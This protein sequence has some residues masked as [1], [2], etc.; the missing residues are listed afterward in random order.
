MFIYYYGNPET[1]QVSYLKAW[2]AKQQAM[3]KRFGTFEASYCNL[4]RM[5]EVIKQSNPGTYTAFKESEP[6]AN[7]I[8]TFH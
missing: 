1:I 5:L 8:T 2:Q 7:D 6:D 3:E 4:P